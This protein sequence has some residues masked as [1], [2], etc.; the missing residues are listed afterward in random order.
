M[1]VSPVGG[2]RGN[3]VRFIEHSGSAGGQW[4]CHR[5]KINHLRSS[6]GKGGSAARLS[7]SICGFSLPGGEVGPGVGPPL[8]R[9][10]LGS[11]CLSVPPS[12]VPSP[13]FPAP[14]HPCQS[15]SRWF[16][17][18]FLPSPPPFSLGSPSLLIFSQVLFK[19]TLT[20][21]MNGVPFSALVPFLCLHCW[22]GRLLS[23]SGTSLALQDNRTNLSELARSP[24]KL[25]NS[26]FF[27]VASGLFFSTSWMVNNNNKK[28]FLLKSVKQKRIEGGML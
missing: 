26:N 14:P 5:L 4:K 19:P 9:T 27:V 28:S 20:G 17:V 13:S 24:F 7:Q 21:G 18:T 23:P 1:S 25:V 11:V 22:E 8:S 15:P 12:L 3:R 16:I 10:L 6:V 2:G